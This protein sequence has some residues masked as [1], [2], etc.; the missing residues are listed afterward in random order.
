MRTKSINIRHA[1]NGGE[2]RI[3]N[4]LVD[5]FDEENNTVY[6][7]HGCFWHGHACGTNYNEEKWNAT[8]EREQAI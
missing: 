3:D 7:F 1:E 5:G 2:N 8:L 6:E 4:Y